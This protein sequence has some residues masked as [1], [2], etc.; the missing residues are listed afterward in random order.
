MAKTY[1]EYDNGQL[2]EETYFQAETAILVDGFEGYFPGGIHIVTPPHLSHGYFA[3]DVRTPDG[4]MHK[5]VSDISISLIEQHAL[6]LYARAYYAQPPERYRVLADR[7]GIPQVSA[8]VRFRSFGL[9]DVPKIE[10]SGEGTGPTES[11]RKKTDEWQLIL[12]GTA[13]DIENSESFKEFCKQLMDS[14]DEST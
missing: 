11:G 6:M 12:L 7:F 3:I 14:N 13:W 10:P 5:F 4:V 1:L 9:H 8:G 2:S